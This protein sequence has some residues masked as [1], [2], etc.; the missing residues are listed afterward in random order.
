MTNILVAIRRAYTVHI[1]IGLYVIM[2]VYSHTYINIHIYHI[3]TRKY[4]HI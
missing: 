4:I 2:Y 1:D 3:Y